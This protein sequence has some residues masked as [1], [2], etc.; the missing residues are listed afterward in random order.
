VIHG[1]VCGSKLGFDRPCLH[2]KGRNGRVAG[3]LRR[4]EK[5]FSS[6][7]VSQIEVQ[8]ATVLSIKLAIKASLLRLLHPEMESLS[9]I[10]V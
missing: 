7:E 1:D 10:R 2:G 8:G 9:V 4:Q 5:N 6:L 3:A